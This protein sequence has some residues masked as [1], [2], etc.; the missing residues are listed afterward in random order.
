MV[1]KKSYTTAAAVILL[2]I[3]FR[4]ALPYIVEDYVN[5]TLN[6]LPGYKGH[7]EDVDLSLYRGA[8]RIEGLILEEEGGNPKYPFL[9]IAESD[10]SIEW[11]SLFK[12]KVVGE[13]IMRQPQLNMVEAKPNAAP[14]EEPTKEHWTEVVKDLMPITINRFIVNN[15]KLAYLDF[16]KKPSIDLHI[17]DMQM[18]ALNLANV[19]DAG[20]ELPSTVRLTG[21]SVGGGALEGSMKANL[22]KEIP[23]FDMTAQLTSVDLTSINDFIKAY[24]KFDVERGRMDL[25]SEL[26]LMDGQ[27]N[28]YVKPFFENVKVLNWEKDKQEDGFFRAAWEAVAGLFT[29]AAENQKRD[30]I[31]TQVPIEGNIN[32]PDTDATATFLNILRHAFIKAFNKGIEAEASAGQGKE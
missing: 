16:N 2:L 4:I 14:T 29:E 7:V 1:L 24:G 18:V 23:D 11:K 21:T 19:E 25:Y 10:L 3:A 5:R 28:G 32:Q 17:S 30:Q 13:V 20:N 8:Y 9:K 31:A 26:K 6:A 22:L 27:L 12:G 15:G